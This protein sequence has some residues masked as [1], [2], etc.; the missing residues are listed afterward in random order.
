MVKILSVE[1]IRAADAFT[2]QHEPINSWALMERAASKLF[3]W[4][5]ANYTQERQIVLFCGSGNNGGDGLALARMLHEAGFKVQVYLLELGKL[6]KDCKLNLE[7]L[8]LSY[9]ILDAKN[10]EFEVPA[11]TLIIDAIFG[12][13]LNR[14][15]S[16]FSAQVIQSINQTNAEVI[17]VDMPSGLFAENN[18]ENDSRSIIQAK[19]TLSFQF[20]KLAFLLPENSAFVGSWQLLD[21]GLHPTY[22][23]ETDSNHFYITQV[24]AVSMLKHRNRFSHKGT[25]GHAV[26]LAGSK[27]KVGAA[28]LASKACLRSG[29][30][31]LSIQSPAIA[32]PILQSQVPEA[33]VLADKHEEYIAELKPEIFK[34]TIAIGPGIGMDEQ[35]QLLLKRI[36]QE[37]NQPLV[38]D[39]DAL[40]I[41]AENRTWLS[42]LPQG[43]II[44]PHPG[45]FKRLVGDWSSDFDRLQKQ[46]DFAQKFG[47]YVVLKGQHSSVACPNGEVYFNSTGNPGMATGGSGDA[48]TGIIVSFLAQNYAPKEA[49]ILGVYVHGLAGDITAEKWGE[50]SMLPSD[51]IESLADAFKHLNA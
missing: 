14:K 15:V 23:Q 4:I 42:F 50:I 9:E 2:I 49:A 34:H 41:L 13:G 28:L 43:T 19:S 27:G 33:M 32:Y 30:G 17:A 47:I 37:T 44:T 18:E 48:L 16:G 24:D 29:V 3:D 8:P 45:E 26:I 38:L 36:I 51:L 10:F 39:A 20:P 22:I 5:Q 40:N 7:K 46:I 31:L 6:S 35:T 11:H 21:I 25:F 12:T 1:Q